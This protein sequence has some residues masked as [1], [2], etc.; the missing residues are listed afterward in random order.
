MQSNLR[1]WYRTLLGAHQDINNRHHFPTLFPNEIRSKSWNGKPTSF[2]MHFSPYN[3]LVE[4]KSY[5]DL[6][7]CGQNESGRFIHRVQWRS[8]VKINAH[9]FTLTTFHQNEHNTLTSTIEW[10]GLKWIGKLRQ[11]SFRWRQL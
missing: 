9:H 7:K 10:R 6:V 2:Q 3:F 4:V 1:L 11:F 8:I 5:S